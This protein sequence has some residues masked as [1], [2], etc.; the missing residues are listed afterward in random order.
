MQTVFL[1]HKQIY[2]MQIA[3]FLAFVFYYKTIFNIEE[4]RILLKTLNLH[5]ANKEVRSSDAKGNQRKFAL[6]TLK[7][8]WPDFQKHN[9]TPGTSGLGLLKRVAMCSK[10][11]SPICVG[12]CVCV[13]FTHRRF[14]LLELRVF[15]KTAKPI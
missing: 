9:F 5:L 4:F 15:A 14:G 2:E 8:I 10:I 13:R 7:Q 11:S 12:V 6:S 1:T 3:I